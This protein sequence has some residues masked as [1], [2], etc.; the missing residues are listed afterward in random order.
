MENTTNPKCTRCKC[1]WKPDETDIKTSGL[2]CKTCKKCRAIDLKKRCEHNKRKYHCIECCGSGI[3]EHNKRRLECRECG[4][5]RFCEHN[6]IRST[7]RECNGSSFCQ[8]NKRRSTCRECG[9]GSICQHGRHKSSCKECGG[10]QIC[11]HNRIISKCRD[12]GGASICEHNRRRSQCKECNLALYLISLQRK[13]IR[14]CFKISN[15]EKTNPS[16]DY[17]GCD[18]KYFME[19][20][21]KKMDL[22]NKFSDIEMTWDNIHIDHIKPISSF[23]LDDEDEFLDCCH[24]TNMQPLL[25]EI[26]LSK[27]CKWTDKNEEFWLNNIK[28]KEYMDLYIS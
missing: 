11:K 25:V 24:Y 9:G 7:C 3:C 19:Y 13:Q 23:N 1:Y 14:R 15:L 8:H 22:F 5:I 6:I 17:L 18:M 27:S 10:S 21:Q 16:I 28:G 26:N 2:V 4:G 20:F 12:C